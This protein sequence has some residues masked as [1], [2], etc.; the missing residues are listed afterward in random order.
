MSFKG[1]VTIEIISVDNVP[2]ADIQGGSDPYV[3]VSI[4]G[5]TKKTSVKENDLNPVYNESLINYLPFFSL[6]MFYFQ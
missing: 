2:K 6:S 5:T 1:T 3:T 4:G